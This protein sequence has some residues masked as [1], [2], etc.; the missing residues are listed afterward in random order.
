MGSIINVRIFGLG[1]LL[2]SSLCLGGCWLAAAGAGAEV[3][4]VATQ[5]DRSVAET[6]DDQ[7]IVSSVKV[8]L[9]AD[10]TVSGLDINVDSFKG[11][12]TLKGVVASQKEAT[13]AIALAR[14]VKGVKAVQSKLFVG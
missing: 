4:Y 12:V 2:G 1:L 14:S 6:I 10:S 7:G 3:A 8:K 9:L 5:E 13:Q 11:V